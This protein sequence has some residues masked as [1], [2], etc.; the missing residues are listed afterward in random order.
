MSNKFNCIFWT[1]IPYSDPSYII[2]CR[3]FVLAA[4]SSTSLHHTS[5]LNDIMFGEV[6]AFQLRG[7]HQLKKQYNTSRLSTVVPRPPNHRQF[8]HTDTPTNT[9]TH[10]ESPRKHAR[11][12]DTYPGGDYTNTLTHTRTQCQSD[13]VPCGW[14][15]FCLFRWFKMVTTQ[16]ICDPSIESVLIVSHIKAH[17]G[18]GQYFYA[19][20][21]F[22]L[23]CITCEHAVHCIY[24]WRQFNPWWWCVSELTSQGLKRLR[25]HHIWD[26]ELFPNEGQWNFYVTATL[27]PCFQNTAHVRVFVR[28]IHSSGKHQAV[29]VVDC[30]TLLHFTFE[31]KQTEQWD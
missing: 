14:I 18:T 23:L 29:S 30:I 28:P 12:T 17:A 8:V 10:H 20:F 6:E 9:D 25:L 1:G 21:L 11:S 27:L 19:C 24:N 5:L 15:Q 7:E 16:W 2:S 3:F 4:T 26:A 22:I 31:C 13:P